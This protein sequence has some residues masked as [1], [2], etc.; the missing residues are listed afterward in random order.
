[1]EKI[2]IMPKEDTLISSLTDW[3]KA[4]NLRLEEIHNPR[5]FRE[6]VDMLSDSDKIELKLL[7]LKVLCH[8]KLGVSGKDGKRAMV[9]AEE[10]RY[11]ECS[12]DE[13]RSDILNYIPKLYTGMTL[14]YIMEN[15]YYK[16]HKNISLT[17]FS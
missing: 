17:D 15:P 9:I 16:E 10:K 8:P 14:Y 5:Y 13:V 1:M 11:A 12:F 3:F 6:F 4:R 7:T 2:E